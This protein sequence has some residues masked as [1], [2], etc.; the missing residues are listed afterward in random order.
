M[1]TSLAI[2]AALLL[3]LPAVALYVNASLSR[4]Q[5][6]AAAEA[7][8]LPAAVNPAGETA[9]RD[10]PSAPALEQALPESPGQPASADSQPASTGNQ[11]AFSGTPSTWAKAPLLEAAMNEAMADFPGEY[12]V[13]VQDL[14]SG[15]RFTRNPDRRYHPASTIK[16]PVTLYTLEQYRAGKASWQ[17]VIQYTPADFESPGGGAFETAAY[18]DWYP[19]EN[20]VNRSLIYSNNVA[21]NMLGRHFGWANIEAW[22]RTI[23][24]D[25]YRVDGSPE[26]T[27]LSALGWWL[28]LYK[29]SQEDPESAELLLKPLGEVDY[30]GRI[31]AGLPQGTA[32]LHKFGSYNGHYHDTAV[33]Y[34][35]QPYILVVLT[36]GAREDEADMAI[37]R[38]SA[39]IFRVM[40]AKIA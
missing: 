12:S 30:S 13:A 32:H 34:G 14:K 40:T 3:L 9:H 22:T 2:P 35:E 36:H 25:L 16:M 31:T 33:I 21:V 4:P 19:I 37:A 10:S 17:D 18:Y 24:G 15:Q 11:V 1:R 6:P 28:H 26:I 7:K 39:A 8:P 23:G 5:P 38:L 20:L 27:A 29:L